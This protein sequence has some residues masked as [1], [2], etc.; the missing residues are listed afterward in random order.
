LGRDTKSE[1]NAT[2]ENVPAL[3][4]G[5]DDVVIVKVACGSNITLAL[6]DQG[7]LYAS[8]TFRVC[9]WFFFKIM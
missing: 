1:D 9:R 4:Q 6:S 5:L 2:E 8:G 7:Q 3:A